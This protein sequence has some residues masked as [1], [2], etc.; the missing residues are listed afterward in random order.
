VK[1]AIVFV[2]RFEATRGREREGDH[3]DGL[4]PQ[5]WNHLKKIGK[6]REEISLRTGEEREKKGRKRLT[7][8]RSERRPERERLELATAAARPRPS[9]SLW[10]EGESWR[11]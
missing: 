10:R 7:A 9:T 2:L 5:Q 11:R 6:E 4:L 8:E 1:R 3:Q